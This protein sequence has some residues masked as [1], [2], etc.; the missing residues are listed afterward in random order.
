V[1]RWTCAVVLLGAMLLLA[2]APA[3]AA[4]TLSA[5]DMLLR[6]ISTPDPAYH[7]EQGQ[8]VQGDMTVSD[9]ILTSQRWR[10]DEWQHLLR[11]F[12]PAKVAY[13]GWMMLYITGGTNPVKPGQKMGED[14]MGIALAQRTQA[15]VA[16]LYQVPNQPIMGGLGETGA[17]EHS[18]EMFM[19]NGDPTWPLLFPMAKSGVRAMDALQEY[20]AKAWGQKI[21][22]FVV[23]GGSKRGW[24][25]WLVAAGDRSGRVKAIVPIVFDFLNIRKQLPHSIEL[26]GHYSEAIQDFVKRDLPQRAET[27]RGQ[28]LW[29]SV[30]PY[31]WRKELT[32]PKLIMNAT[33][34]FFYNTDGL[35]LYWDDL[36]GP[37]YVYYAPNS[38]H[39]M[40]NGLERTLDTVGA[41]FRTVATGSKMPAISW[42]RQDNGASATI[43]ITAPAAKAALVWAAPCDT[44]DFRLSHWVSTP[45]TRNGDTFTAT[46]PR[47]EGKNLTLFGQA[48]FEVQG[49]PCYLCTQPMIVRK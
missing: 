25:T 44:T 32:L 29:D 21:T 31:T 36:T 11:V 14:E 35:N 34:D 43:T 15:P 23:S 10:G 6:Y 30:D 4:E 1:K 20:A 22:S 46:I 9:L 24:T 13:P 37:K 42:T 2:V 18:F 48:E 33:N 19:Q 5:H 27:P 39:G 26:F 8:V 7:W 17:I 49:L 45:M 28:I 38:L 47:P 3:W 40:E 12:R 41:F 16:M